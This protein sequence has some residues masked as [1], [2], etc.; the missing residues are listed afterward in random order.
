MPDAATA[1]RPSLR[2]LNG[3]AVATVVAAGL[4]LGAPLLV[5]L[6][7]ALFL[8]ILSWPL[9]EWLLRRRVPAALAVLVTMLVLI[10][11]ISGFVLLVLGSLGE[12]REV[13]PFYLRE[14]QDR[15]TYTIEWWQQ[16]GI[17]VLDWIPE[18]WRKP[19]SIVELASGTV[20]GT[21]RLLTEGTIVLLTLVFL[22]FEG[23][24]LPRKLER[25]P[26]RVRDQL[27]HFAQ[28]SRVLQR[29]L[30][31]KML[32]ALLIGVAVGAWLS[33][34][35]IDFPVLCAL[36]AF[37]FHFV[38][39]VGAIV[40]AAPAMLLAVIQHDT[41]TAVLVGVGY[42]VI[43]IVLGNLLEPALMGRRLDLSPL[44]VFVS[45]IVWGWLWGTIGMFLS[46]PLTMAIKIVL[47]H[48]RDWAWAGRLLGGAPAMAAVPASAAGDRPTT[49]DDDG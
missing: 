48:S 23:I 12:L 33:V 22:L 28:V 39:N 20:A 45:L 38:P 16:K 17:A 35:R 9:A 26:P 15:A 37:A 49:S 3:L 1:R 46:V 2:L 27:M 34:L 24:V 42:L 43:G 18:R 21:L 40:A 47:E 29:Y 14:I 4:R 41:G 7:L 11:A 44:V 31:I 32:M 13:G 8:A 36:L 30:A 25:L 6:A 10:A 19:Q 5:P